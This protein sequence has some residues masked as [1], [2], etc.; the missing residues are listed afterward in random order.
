MAVVGL[1]VRFIAGAGGLAFAYFTSSG[2]G[3]GSAQVGGVHR[4][5][6]PTHDLE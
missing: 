2:S 3:T 6:Q 1:V 4:V 5:N